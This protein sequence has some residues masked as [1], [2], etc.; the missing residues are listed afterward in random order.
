MLDEETFALELLFDDNFQQQVR[1]VWATLAEAGIPSLAAP[2]HRRHIPH[3]SLAGGPGLDS[4]E[5]RDWNDVVAPDRIAFD[6]VASFAGNGG[7]VFYA[8]RA[9]CALLKYHQDVLN[10]Y[11]SQVQQG[12]WTQYRP[13]WW[14]PHCTLA[15]DVTALDLGRAMTLAQPQLPL[16]GRPAGIDLVS[17][18]TGDATRLIT[19]PAD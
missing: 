13:G 4:V 9:T 3:I 6:A 14:V 5:P 12:V 7:V 11:S 18:R 1:R 10:A 2:T 19:F 16:E 15:Q 8:A 17:L